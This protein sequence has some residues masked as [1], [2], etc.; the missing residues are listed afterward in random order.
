MSLPAIQAS[1]GA[2]RGTVGSPFPRRVCKCWRATS[3]V[4]AAQGL[5]V[6]NLKYGTIAALALDGKSLVESKHFVVK[7]VTGA[8]NADDVAGRD[9]RFI[10]QPNG[11]SLITVLGRGPVLTDG[12]NSEVPITVALGNRSLLDVYLS[13]GGFELYVNGDQWQFY[14][15]TPG[16]RFALH[17]GLQRGLTPSRTALASRGTGQAAAL[18]QVLP[19]GKILPLSVL[20]QGGRATAQF[21]RGAAYVRSASR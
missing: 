14:C 10:K 20:Q 8:R 12:K 6:Q 17:D 4:Q 2:I 15:D 13:G 5:Q 1:C 19:D 11:Q 7:M 18:Q 3:T 16:T 21:P 9:P